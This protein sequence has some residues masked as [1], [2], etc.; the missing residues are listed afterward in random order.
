MVLVRS[1]LP[2]PSDVRACPGDA[3]QAT[4]AEGWTSVSTKVYSGPVQFN[5][6]PT[7]ASGRMAWRMAST[8]AAVNRPGGE[9][10]NPWAMPK[11]TPRPYPG[12]QP[13]IRVGSTPE[14]EAPRPQAVPKGQ[15]LEEAFRLGRRI[16]IH[17]RT[18]ETINTGGADG[19]RASGQRV[20]ERCIEVLPKGATDGDAGGVAQVPVGEYEIVR[21]NLDPLPG[22]H[23][24][25]DL[26]REVSPFSTV[27]LNQSR[28]SGAPNATRLVGADYW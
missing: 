6:P 17:T 23:R 7:V 21:S 19:S 3:A 8:T 13:E 5:A 9:G 27:G 28:W 14:G 26:G 1:V 16:K 24:R 12:V 20:T 10:E 15:L 18:G 11:S 25:D 4:F 22:Y 2:N